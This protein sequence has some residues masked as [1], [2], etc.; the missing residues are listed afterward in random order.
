VR[1]LLSAYACEP[2]K[3]S[4]PEVGFQW[5]LSLSKLGHEVHVLTRKNNEIHI[6]KYIKENSI[7]N[8][9]FHYFD[10]SPFFLKVFKGK[11]NQYPYFYC[12]IWQAGIYFYAKKIIKKIKFD[13]IHHVTFA[14]LRFPSFLCLF[15]IPFIFGPLAG[16]EKIPNSLRSKLNFFNKVKELIRDLHNKIIRYSPFINL[17]LKYTSKIF[18]N[19][20][21][22][23]MLISKK[24][25]HKTEIMLAIGSED[26]NK[27]EE[28]L[29]KSNKNKFKLCFVGNL[30][31]LKGLDL[32][33]AVVDKLKNKIDVELKIAGDGPLK[34]KLSRQVNEHNLNDKIKFL[35]R[36]NKKELKNLYK[37][38]N[39]LIAPYLRDSGGFTILEAFECSLPVVTLNTGGPGI[40]TNS[41]C[42]IKIDIKNKNFKEI[43]DEIFFKI[44]HLSQNANEL[45]EMKKNAILRVK[46]F[47]WIA[48]A[49]VI[50]K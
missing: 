27:S 50:Y 24:Y 39:L 46:D 15:G 49:K 47:S 33:I 10:F 41:K 16:G 37:E 29:N 13:Y 32:V 8:I 30:N 44:Y 9:S 36:I 34:K 19:S 45:N 6:N 20:E 12:W 23:K 42:G 4:E 2:Y 28:N 43:V 31:Y 48:K 11:K 25:H 18:V 3:G 35:G 7:K 14:S 26:F 22:T 1:I 21:S 5:A 40:I 38:S 17:T